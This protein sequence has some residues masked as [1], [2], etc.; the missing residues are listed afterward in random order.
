MLTRALAMMLV[1]ANAVP[2]S[3]A[4]V[5]AVDARR[6]SIREQRPFVLRGDL[7]WNTLAGLGLGVSYAATAH[8]IVDAGVGYV[9]SGPKAGARLRWNFT[10]G[11]LA[12]FVA[13]GGIWSAGLARPQTINQGHDDEFTFHVGQAAYAQYVVGVDLQDDDRFSYRMEIGWAQDLRARDLRLLSGTPS[14]ADWNEVRTVAAG[15]LV[16]G[17][18]IGYAF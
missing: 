14:S 7:G 9:L 2:A 11:A 12:P 16:I 3:A 4:P 8:L 15:G 17:G 6:S 1:F 13:V 18:A 10:T 5:A